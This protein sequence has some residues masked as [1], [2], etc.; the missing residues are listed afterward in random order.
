MNF[1]GMWIGTWAII[2]ILFLLNNGNWFGWGRGGGNSAA[3][4][5]NWMNNNN[6]HDNTVDII[7]NNTQWQQAMFANQNLANQSTLI[8][9]W[10]CNTNNNIEKAILAWQQNTA[11]IIASSAANVQRVL[12]KLCEQETDRLRTALAEARVIANN[13]QQTAD[14]VNAIRP[15]PQASYIVS[16]PYT[17][18]Y[19]PA[20][21]T[22]AGA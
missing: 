22:T 16:S 2:L 21:T 5:L 13:T 20:T 14:I 12:D 18:I 7:N 4:L 19:P 11:S 15:F 9:Q 8:T 1:T 17:S 3:W 6:N 10:F